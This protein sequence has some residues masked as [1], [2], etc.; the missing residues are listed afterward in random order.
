MGNLIKYNRTWLE[1]LQATPKISEYPD[2]AKD[3]AKTIAFAS[4]YYGIKRPTDEVLKVL[5]MDVVNSYPTLRKDELM[6]AFKLASKQK[7]NV[8][9]ELYGR[10]MNAWLVHQ[11]INAYWLF[12]SKQ[13][14]NA[15]ALNGF[16]NVREKCPEEISKS[17]DT[18]LI[19][20]QQKAKKSMTNWKNK[21][22]YENKN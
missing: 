9:L 21:V 1:K 13:V 15:R 2:G 11:I 12:R 6:E 14:K 18:M 5:A 20:A 17:F 16:E 22:R 7:I 19:K 10:P 8:S 4:D 3:I